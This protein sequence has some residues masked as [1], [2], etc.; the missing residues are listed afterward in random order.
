MAQL[1]SVTSVAGL[2]VLVLGAA[3]VSAQQPG[4][5]PAPGLQTPQVD[6]YVVGTAR[7]PDTGLPVRDM[8]LEDAMLVAL[9]QN[10]ELRVARMNP[11]IQDYS[12]QQVRAAFLPTVSGTYSYSSTSRISDDS[13]Q[14]V[15]RLVTGN[16]SFN[17]RLQQAMPWYG[18][19]LSANWNNSRGTTNA[20]NSTFNP[21]IRSSVQ[22][23]YTQPLLQNLLIDNTRNSLRTSQITRQITDITLLNQ[24]ESTKTQVRNAYWAL[25]SALEQIEIQRRSLEMAQRQL[26]ENR[27]RVE[28]G[29]MAPIDIAQP[30]ASVATAEQA[31]LNAEIAWRTAEL[32]L[33]R[34]LVSGRDDQLYQVTIN[35]VDVPAF[36]L[37]SVDIASAIEA[38]LAQRSDLDTSRRQL[39]IT[40]MN[41][42]LSRNATRPSLN[43]TANYSLEGTGGNRYEVDR[44]QGTRT[45][46]N[47]GGYIDAL[48]GLA[49]LDTPAWSF[50]FNFSYPI[51]TTSARA[52]YARSQLQR[53]Q[54]LTELK[55]QELAVATEVT[56]AG[57]AVENTYKQLQAS[58]KTREVA[59]RNLEA[60][61]TRFEVGMSNNF[62]VAQLQNSLTSARLN[63]LNRLIAY[64]NAVAEFERVQR[65]PR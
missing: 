3:T 26:D 53:E 15:S 21:N 23:S 59:E 29:T 22:F 31:L 37:Q 32:N 62:Q 33:K 58:Q 56:N 10:L 44:L 4:A 5:A 51:G 13:V 18:G 55:A 63:E 1:R 25:R 49:S 6:R 20:A 43:M 54:E 39:Q 38:A 19:S 42:A 2:A 24:I 47:A 11:E 41:L 7:P 30:E 16:Q 17:G 8:T 45:L 35:P 40:E 57:L 61:L 34:L 27:I 9:E 46:I 65:F 60:E 36:T 64:I 28:I 12:L 14:G 48:S 50:N 52:S